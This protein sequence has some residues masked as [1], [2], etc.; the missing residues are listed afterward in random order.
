MSSKKPTPNKPK[1][2]IKPKIKMSKTM[3]SSYVEY[4]TFVPTKKN[5]KVRTYGNRLE[6]II[7]E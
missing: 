6:R 4:K 3:P 2:I 5:E 1:A 7:N